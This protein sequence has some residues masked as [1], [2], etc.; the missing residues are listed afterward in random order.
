[1]RIVRSL[2]SLASSA[3]MRLEVGAR[4]EAEADQLDGA[5]WSTAGYLRVR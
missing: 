4:L 1:M 2:S 3:A 5:D